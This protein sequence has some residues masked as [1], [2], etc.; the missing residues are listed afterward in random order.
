MLLVMLLMSLGSGKVVLEAD[1][2]S[3]VASGAERAERHSRDQIGETDGRMSD[4]ICQ[5]FLANAVVMAGLMVAGFLAG[6]AASGGG[7]LP[8]I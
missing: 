8:R 6:A 4:P 5:R 1:G 7:F 3:G 2:P